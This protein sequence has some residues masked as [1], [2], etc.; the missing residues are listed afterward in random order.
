MDAYTHTILALLW[1]AGIAVLF[2]YKGRA[3]TSM[4]ALELMLDNLE[5]NGFIKTRTNADGE[6]ELIKV[7]D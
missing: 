7:D 2:Y 5:E 4:T 1:S 6:K 3:Q